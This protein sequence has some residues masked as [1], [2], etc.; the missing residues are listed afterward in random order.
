LLSN[1]VVACSICDTLRQRSQDGQCTVTLSRSPCMIFILTC[2]SSLQSPPLST[3]RSTVNV[4]P[5]ARHICA[6]A[7]FFTSPKIPM[8][9]FRERNPREK[10]HHQ[11][12]RTR[13]WHVCITWRDLRRKARDGQLIALEKLM[14][15]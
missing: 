4:Q 8:I 7:T 10:Q 15:T 14:N 2:I 6:A 9:C 11:A 13:S 12:Q 1:V 5:N 3:E